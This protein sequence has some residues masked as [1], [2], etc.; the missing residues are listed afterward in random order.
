MYSH[1]K[2]LILATSSLGV[3]GGLLMVIL[4][5]D[6]PYRQPSQ[7]IDLS[8]FFSV[9]K[10]REFRSAAFGYFGHIWEL[11]AFWAFVPYILK[12]YS[13]EHAQ[14]EFNI[15]V[16]SFLIIGI[17]ALACI[18][19]GYVAQKVGT[20][21]TAFIALLLS[22]IC[23]LVS[24]LIFACEFEILFISFLIFW[25]MFVIADSPLFYQH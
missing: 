10:N 25:G 11:Y 21:R 14:V 12:K 24:P 4:V 13:T 1:G 19:S 9:F 18:Y 16:L 6:G 17:G 15:P 22:C 5:P 8:A 7:K 3:L 2:P 23:C 20:K